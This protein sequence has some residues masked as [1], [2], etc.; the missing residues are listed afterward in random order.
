MKAIVKKMVKE[1]LMDG[2]RRNH[3]N[4]LLTS[5]RYPHGGIFTSRQDIDHSFSIASLT[6]QTWQE[7]FKATPSEFPRTLNEFER[8]IDIKLATVSF[9]E[10]NSLINLRFKDR[11]NAELIK[12]A[13]ADIQKLR[14][15]GCI[16]DADIFERCLKS[17]IGEEE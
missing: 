5:I 9:M 4:L 15:L 1:I 11:S 17:R 16:T 14:N 10:A 3:C 7:M 2:L 13:K 6:L 8:K 12:E